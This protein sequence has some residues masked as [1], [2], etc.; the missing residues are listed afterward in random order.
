MTKEAVQFK[1]Q[2]TNL[3]QKECHLS[4]NAK[5]INCL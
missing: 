4:V 1:V 5:V 3:G 2:P